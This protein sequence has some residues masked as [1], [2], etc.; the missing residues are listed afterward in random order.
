MKTKTDESRKG[1]NA[2]VSIMQRSNDTGTAQ[3]THDQEKERAATA[4]GPAQGQ[5]TL[6]GQGE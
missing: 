4:A 6:H 3:R 2:W 1:L 5:N